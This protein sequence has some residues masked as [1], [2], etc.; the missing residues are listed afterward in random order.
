MTNE[1]LEQSF[2]NGVEVG[3]IMFK[4][5]LGIYRVCNDG[6]CIRREN[7]QS[8]IDISKKLGYIP[9]FCPSNQRE[10][11]GFYAIK[12]MHSNN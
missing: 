7:R 2:L 12:L 3:R 10:F 1:V 8:I 11:I 5:E 6:N 9:Y 4:M